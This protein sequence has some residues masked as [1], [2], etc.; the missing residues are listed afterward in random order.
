MHK[1]QELNCSAG[2]NQLMDTVVFLRYSLAF[3]ICFGLLSNSQ[4]ATWYVDNTATGLDDGTSW[5]NAWTDLNSA[6]GVNPGDTVYI[7]GGNV[8]Q[9]YWLTDTTWQLAN[10]TNNNP[11]TYTVGQDAGHNGTV[12]LNGGG[13]QANAVNA[14]LAWVTI[15]GSYDDQNNLIISNFTDGSFLFD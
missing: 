1:T 12:I 15:D 11:V 13:T 7:S 8:S 14:T 3:L 4:G 6:S 5:S 2:S 10:G 9:T